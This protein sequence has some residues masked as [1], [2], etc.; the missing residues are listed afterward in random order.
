MLMPYPRYRATCAPV[1]FCLA[2]ACPGQAQNS[3]ASPQ[4][5]TPLPPTTTQERLVN[6]AGLSISPKYGW[7]T[8][9]IGPLRGD[10][11]L[12]FG[13]KFWPERFSFRSL[14]LSGTTDLLPGVRARTQLRRHEGEQKAFQV[15]ID[16]LYLE[17][18]DQY[19]APTWNAGVSLR[20]GT[21]PYGAGPVRAACHLS[22]LSPRQVNC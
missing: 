16:E 18:F 8:D 17:A 15:D 6:P 3:P 20:L 10:F 12:S 4:E 11:D 13:I 5:T 2:F 14:I 19:R 21:R 7:H 22:L 9:F 1:G